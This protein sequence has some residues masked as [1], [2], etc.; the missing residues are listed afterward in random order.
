MYSDAKSFYPSA[1]WDGKSVFPKVE[2]VFAFN[3]NMNVFFV[4]T[5]I[6]QNFKQDGNESAFLKKYITIHM[7]LYFNIFL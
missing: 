4:E 7:V 2:S 5:F 6:I 3:P 1:M